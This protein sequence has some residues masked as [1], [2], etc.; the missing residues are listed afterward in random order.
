MFTNREWMSKVERMRSR[1]TDAQEGWKEIGEEK[2]E[3]KSSWTDSVDPRA[4]SPGGMTQ[5]TKT[6]SSSDYQVKNA[7]INCIRKY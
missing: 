2:S 5:Y 3:G 6:G 1:N 4:P 7:I